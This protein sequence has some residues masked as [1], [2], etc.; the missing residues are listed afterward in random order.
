VRCA[1]A[2]DGSFFILNSD[3]DQSYVLSSRRPRQREHSNGT[4]ALSNAL[5]WTCDSPV[6]FVCSPPDIT[7]GALDHVD[8]ACLVAYMTR[9][10]NM[11]SSCHRLISDHV[12]TRIISPTYMGYVL[13]HLAALITVNCVSIVT[14]IHLQVRGGQQGS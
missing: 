4:S 3:T 10:L 12:S 11:S 1:V 6:L 9:K 13:Q 7:V 14:V 2:G 5:N 8:A